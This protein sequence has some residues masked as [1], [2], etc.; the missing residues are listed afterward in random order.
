MCDPLNSAAGDKCGSFCKEKS[1]LLQLLASGRSVVAAARDAG[2]AV[3]IFG[4][5]GLR[6]GPQSGTKVTPESCQQ[7]CP[8]VSCCASCMHGHLIEKLIIREGTSAALGQGVLAI[9]GGVDITDPTTLGPAAVGGRRAGCV[10][11]RPRLWPPS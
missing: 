2:K 9:R 11:G 10:R 7:R 1:L 4:E 8:A 3:E 6:E 5:L